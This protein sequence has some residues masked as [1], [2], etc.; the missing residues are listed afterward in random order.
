MAEQDKRNTERRITDERRD[1]GDRRK[2]ARRREDAELLAQAK[3]AWGE[4]SRVT[5]TGGGG[6]GGWLRRLFGR[7]TPPTD[8][9]S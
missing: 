9:G 5:R 6:L 1:E 8:D 7:A 2:A 3:Q 4:Y